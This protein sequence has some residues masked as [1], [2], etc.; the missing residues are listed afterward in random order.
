VRNEKQGRGTYTFKDK[1]YEGEFRGNRFEGK[2]KLTYG[3]GDEYAGDFADGRKHGKGRLTLA[4]AREFYEGA[5]EHDKIGGFGTLTYANGDV[6]EGY[7][8][9]NKK[10]G[11]GRYVCKAKDEIWEGAWDMD[12]KHGDFTETQR[13][14]NRRVAGTYVKGQRD[15]QFTTTDESSGTVVAEERWVAGKLQYA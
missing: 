14:T 1:T 8:S 12:V 6:Y 5:F 4:R 10:H 2:G 15:G 13:R 3:N 9:D 7:H 11:K